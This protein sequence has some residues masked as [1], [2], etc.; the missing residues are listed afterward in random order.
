MHTHKE[1]GIYTYLSFSPG[2]G[3]KLK[4]DVDDFYV[5]EVPIDI[6]RDNHGKN[7][8]LKIRLRNWETNRF[9]K[10]L[11]KKLGISRNRIRFAG[12]KDKRSVS[13]QYFC[14]YGLTQIP[15]IEIKDVEILEVFRS[16]ECI[17]LGNLLGNKFRIRVCDAS[18]DGVE[19]IE[20]E[21]NGRFPNFFGVQRFG[22]A[23]P[24]TH[25]V[26]KYIVQ[27]NYKE[28]VR[29]YIGLQSEFNEDEGRKIFWD[30]LDPKAAI[31]KIDRT[32]EY[33]RAMLNH[34]IKN[35]DD[36][37]GAIRVLP[38][39]LAKMFV[40]AYQS[41]LFNIM[42]SKRLEVGVEPTIGDIVLKTDSLGMPVQDYVK[43]TSFNI[44][45]IKKMNREGK[46][47][48]ST[49][50]FG[51]ETKF[52]EG[53]QGE[54]ER[55]VI[56]EENIKRENFRIKQIPELSSKGRRRNILARFKDYSRNDC[57]FSFFLYPGTYATSLMREF[58]KRDE[59][60]YY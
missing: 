1:I 5:E 37:A 26:G 9:V 46:A 44:N 30:S 36:Y 40:H 60:K 19:K 2:V 13:T 39:N 3:G 6:E 51:Y 38:K 59:L 48:I 32:A 7:T 4:K 24:T 29:Y 56:Y 41:Y 12:T 42:V 11:S 8:V 25:V 27:G 53:V 15:D 33:E 57:Y 58:M 45:K 23:R 54:I 16:N 34:L 20:N 31:R 50:L 47:Y 52:S 49:V 17:E 21:L 55:E 14:I 43:V 10:I 35:P 22:A 28:A 18:C